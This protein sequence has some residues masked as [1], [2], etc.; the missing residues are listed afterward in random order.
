VKCPRRNCNGTVKKVDEQ[1]FNELAEMLSDPNKFAKCAQKVAK[2]NGLA[3][4]SN[5]E[6]KFAQLMVLRSIK[7]IAE[8]P[9]SNFDACVECGCVVYKKGH[10]LLGVK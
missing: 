8:E 4:L 2:K 5:E 1:V 7:K 6:L 3:P 10:G 9:D